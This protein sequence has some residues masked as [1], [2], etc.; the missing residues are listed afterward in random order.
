MKKLLCCLLFL[1]P[2]LL[3]AQDK[4]LDIAKK[5]VAATRISEKPVLDG[6]LDDAIWQDA[7]IATELVIYQ[8]NP[9]GTPR[10]RSEIK[11]VYDNIGIYIGAMLYDSHPDSIN[12]ELSQRDGLGNTEWFMMAFDPYRSG[13]DAFEFI[14][15]PTDVQFD[16]KVGPNGEDENWDAVWDNKAV[17]LENGWSV[18][19]KIP[20][21]ALRFPKT[22]VQSWGLNFGRLIA[23]YQEK[24]FWSPLDP[25]VSGFVPQFGYLTELTD[26]KSPTRLQATPFLAFYGQKYSNPSGENSFGRSINGGMDI[27]VGLSDAFTLDMTLIPDFGEA[28]S[29]DQ[30]LNLSPFEVRFDEQRAFFTEGTELFDKANLFYS[31]RIGGTPLR[32]Y[33]VEDQLEEGET[34]VANPDKPQLYNATKITGRTAKGLGIGFFNATSGRT[35]ASIRNEE[36]GERQFET[37]PLT[38]YNVL[39]FD[40]NLPHNSTASIINTTVWRDGDAYDANVTGAFT[41]LRDKANNWAVSGSAILTQKYYTDRTDLGH[42]YSIGLNKTSGNLNFGVDYGVESDTYDPNDLGFLFNNNSRELSGYM[43]YN[44]Y[45]PF[46]IFN[47]MGGGFYMEYERLYE[48]NVFTGFGGEVFSYAQFKNF[49]QVNGWIGFRPGNQFDY[50]EPRTPGRYWQDVPN[51]NVGFNIRSDQRK[52]LYV[53]LNGNYW[54]SQQRGRD[55][56]NLTIQPRYRFSDK[57]NASF[58]V[59]RSIGH[60]DTGFVNNYTFTVLDP[61]TQEPVS[62]S[63]IIF[64]LR[65]R[66]TIEVGVG[67]NYNFSSRMALNLRVRHYWSK[68]VY[69]EFRR[70]DDDG[71]LNPTDYFSEHDNDFNAFNV[72]LIYRWRFAPGSDIFVVWKNSLFASNNRVSPTYFENFNG[73]WDNPQTNQLSLKIVYFLDYATLRGRG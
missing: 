36:G 58:T 46:G 18:E 37:D 31:R 39:V 57:L 20:Y 50:F 54:F 62:Y 27:K 13:I 61:E 47:S 3:F 6:I 2:L 33:D 68:V 66:E 48:P 30:V 63:D 19:I 55:N 49:W 64:G 25:E 9:G 60:D 17:I 24:S 38:N 71:F 44:Q 65:D 12:Q 52:Q 45:E 22:A 69:N 34:V 1:L 43:E 14:V 8:P 70:L 26:I 28:R 42:T 16:A 21:S 72:D 11:V 4:P 56:F 10:F 59:S 51:S 35:F 32:Y 73:L 41:R 5:K 15:T 7:E 67:A 23:R 40:Q 53:R 29:D